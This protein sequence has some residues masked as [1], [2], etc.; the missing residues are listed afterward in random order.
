MCEIFWRS[1][2]TAP[3]KF[4]AL[5]FVGVLLVGGSIVVP[6]FGLLFWISLGEFDMGF[7]MVPALALTLFA[8]A[9]LVGSLHMLSERTASTTGGSLLREA[10]RGWKEKMCP[11]VEIKR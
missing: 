8:L 2:L 1:V 6:A 4:I 7:F 3:I 9:L 11:T 5:T 10:Y